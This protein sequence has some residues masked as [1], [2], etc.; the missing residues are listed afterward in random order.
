MSNLLEEK[1]WIQIE[2]IINILKQPVSNIPD[3]SS[4]YEE[5]KLILSDLPKKI[6]KSIN[7]TEKGVELVQDFFEIVE[8][9]FQGRNLEES[10]GYILLLWFSHE[11]LKVYEPVIST[12]WTLLIV[13][14][15]NPQ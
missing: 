9:S 13:R 7:F 14:I 3:F 12:H 5:L 1:L 6:T 8:L 10:L 11:Y 4:T 15:L 2:Y